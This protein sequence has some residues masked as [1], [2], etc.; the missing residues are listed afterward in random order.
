MAGRSRLL[1][2]FRSINERYREPR[3]AIQGPTRIALLGLRIYLFV[4]VGLML[5]KFVTMVGG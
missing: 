5:Y 2:K 3:L 4:L 1:R